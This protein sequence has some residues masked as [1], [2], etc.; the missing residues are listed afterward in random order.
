MY[1]LKI[2]NNAKPPVYEIDDSVGRMVIIGL[3]DRELIK[4]KEPQTQWIYSCKCRR[5]DGEERYSQTDLNQIKK[6][7]ARGVCRKCRKELKGTIIQM[8]ETGI[9]GMTDRDVIKMKWLQTK[10]K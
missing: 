9:K 4:G 7:K 8:K 3:P 6:G 10:W 5:C 2:N 1:E